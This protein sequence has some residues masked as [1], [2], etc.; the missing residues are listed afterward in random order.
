MS[1]LMDMVLDRHQLETR[2]QPIVSCR[3]GHRTAKVEC[4]LRGPQG[5]N[6]R[7]P[8]VMFE[9][10]RRRRIESSLDLLALRLFLADLSWLCDLPFTVNLHA[11][12]LSRNRAIVDDILEILQAH[13]VRAG[14]LQ[15]E[16]VEAAPEIDE[17]VLRQNVRQLRDA[18]IT[19]ALD[20]FGTAYAN[21]HLMDVLQP[22]I[23]KIDKSLL[24]V[25]PGTSDTSSCFLAAVR[26]GQTV[27]AEIVA[28]GV[29]T[30]AQLEYVRQLGVEYAQG[31]F[32]SRPM[33]IQA[34]Q[35]WLWPADAASSSCQEQVV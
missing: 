22:E 19:M 28:E 35:G 26:C 17:A 32:F 11:S 5:T 6:L 30:E 4:L 34:L 9:Y 3:P 15:I 18:G 25:N 2:Y 27:G 13:S 7:S 29:E 10:A 20:D 1:R 24:P 14:L 21:L 12:T 16:L 33:D 23:I 8:Q 31:F